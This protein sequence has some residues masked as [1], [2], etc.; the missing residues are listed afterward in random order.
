M[1]F[2]ISSNLSFFRNKEFNQF[3]L[4]VFLMSF[5]EALVSIFVPIYLYNLGFPIYQILFFFVLSSFYFLALSYPMTKIVSKIG[6]KR[7]ILFSSPFFVFYL[8]G[9]IF[10]E[11]SWII[12]FILPAILSVRHIL[13]NYGY[14]LNFINHSETE[15]RGREL[16]TL[17]IITLIATA[18]APYLGGLLVELNFGF[19][20]IAGSIFIVAGSAPLFFSQDKFTDKNFSF[21][22]LVGKIFGS[23]DRGNFI[24]FSGYA[25]EQSV[26]SVIWP[27]FIL[28]VIGSIEKTGLIVSLSLVISILVFYL[29][30]QFSDRFNKIFLIKIGNIIHFSA[31]ILRIFAD[32]VFKILFIDSYKHSSEKFLRLPWEAH[33]YDLAKRGDYFEFIVYREIVFNL[34]R[35]I[36]LP[37]IILIFW[38]DFYPFI[39]S[40]IIASVFSLGY[41]F[42]KR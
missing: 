30:G 15:K 5:G 11:S 38:L 10:I 14:H 18:V 42:I 35:I 1:I 9:L 19:V 24:S 16:A 25:I 22:D 8:I 6:A 21:K 2:D 33:S 34:I 31:W 13:F 41:V 39:L 36:V 23:D 26:G 7:A 20:F 37:F 17:G 29:V 27:I 4:A 12:F 40:F 3:Y 32:S 28:V